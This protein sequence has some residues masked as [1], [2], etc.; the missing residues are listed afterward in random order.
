MKLSKYFI[1]GGLL[2][3]AAAP[4]T[5]ALHQKQSVVHADTTKDLSTIMSTGN[6]SF[7]TSYHRF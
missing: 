5:I 4:L 6:R 2:L 7:S 1:L 3:G